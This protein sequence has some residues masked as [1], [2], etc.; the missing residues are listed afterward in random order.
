MQTF[1]KLI[2]LLILVLPAV[3]GAQVNFGIKAGVN[4]ST[5]EFDGSDP[6]RAVRLHAGIVPEISLG[7]VFFIRPELLY[8][9][10]GWQVPDISMKLNYI[11]LPVLAGWRPV[12]DIAILLGPEVGYLAG[13]RR[14][15]SSSSFANV[16]EKF[17]YGVDVGVS[18]RIVKQY[19][20]ELIYGQGFDTLIKAEGRDE[21]NAPTGEIF[22]DG[23]NRV[24]QL[25][26]IFHLNPS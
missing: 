11:S 15:P 5:A 19:S 20:V 10:K 18:Y 4:F 9:A 22:R 2:F 7:K 8:S 21:N 1:S 26:V 14:K 17:D 23:A 6:D 13:I 16:Y 24:I 12:P 3:A 25:G